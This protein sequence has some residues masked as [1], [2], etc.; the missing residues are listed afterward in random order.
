MIKMF[1]KNSLLTDKNFEK[2]ATSNEVSPQNCN[3]V[4]ANTMKLQ[5]GQ[6]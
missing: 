2:G 1:Q 3:F 4:V 6:K 5:Y